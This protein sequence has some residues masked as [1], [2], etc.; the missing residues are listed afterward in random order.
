MVYRINATELRDYVHNRIISL[1]L[2]GQSQL[3]LNSKPLGECSLQLWAP[4]RTNINNLLCA[5]AYSSRT[6]SDLAEIY[7]HPNRP[8]LDEG[9]AK[10]FLEQLV[11]GDKI[12]QEG[13]PLCP[14]NRDFLRNVSDAQRTFVRLDNPAQCKLACSIPWSRYGKERIKDMVYDYLFR[15]GLYYLFRM[16]DFS[17]KS[18]S[19]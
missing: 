8:G 13:F 1:P 5:F 15:E 18:D 2:R 19:K 12:F 11:V 14:R 17:P 9:D 6:E 4:F 10:R 16:G 7:L 3:L